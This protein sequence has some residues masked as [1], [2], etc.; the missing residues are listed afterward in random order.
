MS[1]TIPTPN[2][3]IW[4]WENTK[5]G[6]KYCCVFFP[7]N[8]IQKSNF[9]LGLPRAKLSLKFLR[10][11]LFSYLKSFK[12]FKSHSSSI[13]NLM[14]TLKLFGPR[15][16]HRNPTLF[17]R[18]KPLPI[19]VI[20]LGQQIVLCK[21]AF[22]D[23]VSKEDR[24][25]LKYHASFWEYTWASFFFF[26]SCCPQNQRRGYHCCSELARCR[27]CCWRMRRPSEANFLLA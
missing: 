26:S 25:G 8:L 18:S 15:V 2:L 13:F 14:K 27:G 17:R 20:R 23:L 3:T 5:L 22:S 9:P 12:V 19:K 10:R 6:R 16:R 21:I 7:L 1:S 11:W 4:M 24:N